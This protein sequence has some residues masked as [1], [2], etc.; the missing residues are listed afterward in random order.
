[1]F[2]TVLYSTSRLLGDVSIVVRVR[3]SA[4][5][6]VRSVTPAGVYTSP[7]SGDF[8]SPLLPGCQVNRGKRFSPSATSKPTPKSSMPGAAF[9]EGKGSLLGTAARKR[10]S[11][12]STLWALSAE[13]STKSVSVPPPPPPTLGG[14]SYEPDST[15][16]SAANRSSRR[17]RMISASSS[18]LDAITSGE[19]PTCRC[20]RRYPSTARSSLDMA[21][22]IISRTES[23]MVGADDISSASLPAS[24][25]S[26]SS[27]LASASATPTDGSAPGTML[28]RIASPS[29]FTST[30][31]A[32]DLSPIPS[33]AAADAACLVSVRAASPSSRSVA[34]TEA[35][36]TSFDSLPESRPALST[37]PSL[38]LPLLLLL[39]PLL[40]IP[41]LGCVVLALAPSSS[42]PSPSPLGFTR[43]PS[44][45]TSNPFAM[46]T[47]RFIASDISPLP[48]SL[49]LPLLGAPEPSSGP[50]LAEAA[51][52]SNRIAPAITASASA[53]PVLAPTA[54]VLL[55]SNSGAQ[56]ARCWHTS[57]ERP[58][59]ASKNSTGA[60]SSSRKRTQSARCLGCMVEHGTLAP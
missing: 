33:R 15:A 36:P 58:S 11:S 60:S 40:P 10:C 19:L 47:S 53:S 7:Y 16:F 50:S 30:V 20:I 39:P 56:N 59:S 1:M 41:E 37:T 8:H 38:P 29:T 14:S 23:G 22:F 42:P 46:A 12:A 49:P 2:I 24:S 44:L 52:D 18:V 34:P 55:P 27:A 32:P 6:R 57:T 26:S 35:S 28:Y 5:G 4:R 31:C 51:V 25:S 21:E 45:S 17:A 9:M 43:F 48:L 13:N 3:S 54:D